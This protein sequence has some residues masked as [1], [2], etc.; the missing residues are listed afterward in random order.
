MT[1]DEGFIMLKMKNVFFIITI[2]IIAF[3]TNVA[4]TSQN[5]DKVIYGTDGRMEVYERPEY[6]NWAKSTAIQISNSLLKN[7][8]DRVR[9]GGGIFQD[10]GELCD[11]ERYAS[12]PSPGR[13]SGFLVAPD[14]L[15]TAGHCIQ[16]DYHCQSNSWVF[17]FNASKDGTV[18][19]L[20]NP[21]QIFRCVSIIS[22]ARDNKTQ[23]DYAVIRLDRVALG[24]TPLKFRTSGQVDQNADLVVIGN[25]S[26]L[27]TKVTV[28]GTMRDNTNP[29]FF[30][31]N[32]DT[33]GGN[34]G[35]AVFD[36]RTGLVEGILVRGETDFVNDPIRSCNVVYK[37]KE[38]ECRGEDVTRI[39]NLTKFLPTKN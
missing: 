12:Q 26:G 8:G 22:T 31:A 25:P 10:A 5:F 34:S 38:G 21:Q 30:R 23:N 2:L 18:N 4:Q 16:M 15:V 33:F 17:D 24:R 32:L 36:T 39:T 3:Y 9:V 37:C 27:P 7:E 1:L 11:T 35:S 20:L 28:G 29:I 14:L 13:C 6:K 19:T